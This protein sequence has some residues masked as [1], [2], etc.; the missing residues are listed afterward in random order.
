M[1]KLTKSE[2]LAELMFREMNEKQIRYAREMYANY[3]YLLSRSA[4]EIGL[5]RIED[6]PMI[7]RFMRDLEILFGMEA[8]KGI[9]KP[10]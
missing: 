3:A 10:I 9:D 4:Y 7:K 8:F 6:Y 1:G 2:E 5:S